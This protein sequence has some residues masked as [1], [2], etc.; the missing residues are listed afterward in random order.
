MVNLEPA[1]R[2]IASALGRSPVSIGANERDSDYALLLRWKLLTA[3]NLP[4]SGVI[5][6]SAK[7]APMAVRGPLARHAVALVSRIERNRDESGLD[8]DFYQ[9]I[10]F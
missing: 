6:L 1:V 4:R 8:S 5:E 9:A 10:T 2:N 7:R 3:E